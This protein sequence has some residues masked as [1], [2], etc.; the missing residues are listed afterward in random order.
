MIGW[1]QDDNMAYLDHMMIMKSE[2]KIQ[3]NMSFKHYYYQASK[4]VKEDGQRSY[5]AIAYF[6]RAIEIAPNNLIGGVYNDLANCFRGG[7]KNFAIAEQYYSQAIANN[8]TK[9]FVFYNR[10]ICRYE[11]GDFKGSEKD[12]NIS[13][14]KGW[15]NDYF[16]LSRL[17]KEKL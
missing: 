2:R 17:L 4:F 6:Y 3:D 8:F 11:N 10:A 7:L 1:S 12:L 13:K 15:D 5:D 9:S 16:N 14:L